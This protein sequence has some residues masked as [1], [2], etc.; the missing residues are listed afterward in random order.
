VSQVFGAAYAGAYDAIYQEK[1]YRGE[2]ELI[3]RIFDDYGQRRIKR[4]LDLGCGT[5]NHAFPLGKMGYEVVGVDRSAAMLAEA[6]SKAAALRRGDRPTFAEGDVRN[7]TLPRTF[8]ACLMMFAVLGYQ[9]EDADVASTLGTVRRHLR[10]GGIFI[11]DVWYA[12]AVLTLRPEPRSRVVPLAGGTLRRHSRAELDTSRRR[13]TVIF[14]LCHHEADRVRAQTEETHAIRYFFPQE[15]EVFL[16]AAGLEL[17]RLGE[18]P[19]FE[20]AP[21]EQS[22]NVLGVARASLTA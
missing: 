19:D 21:T 14:Q 16:K 18:F 9:L 7:L 11:F 6:R 8:D 4:V 13:A 2:C 10:P 5:G 20:K 12:P 1:D 22:W 3:Q 17:I 15:L